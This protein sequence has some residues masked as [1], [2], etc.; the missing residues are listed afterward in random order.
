[1][2]ALGLNTSRFLENFAWEMVSD[3]G[4]TQEFSI[5]WNGAEGNFAE[6]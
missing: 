4:V 2:A 3:C 5:T 6:L 1:M